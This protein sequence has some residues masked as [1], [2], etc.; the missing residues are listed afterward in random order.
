[1][2]GRKRKQIFLALFLCMAFLLCAGCAKNEQE[3]TGSAVTE[4][5]ESQAV[6]TEA[7]ET[8]AQETDVPETAETESLAPDQ[9]GDYEETELE[10]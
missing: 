7:Q 5:V 6:E 1:M 3:Q 9:V 8:E 4:A 10:L 2:M